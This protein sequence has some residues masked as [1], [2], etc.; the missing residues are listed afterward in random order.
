[1]RPYS[2]VG[3][4]MIQ[5][6]LYILK[7]QLSLL[8]LDEVNNFHA[9]TVVSLA[10]KFVKHAWCEVSFSLVATQAQGFVF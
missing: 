6:G 1:M 4:G 5:F 10:L 9:T 8:G 7:T 2:P 3:L